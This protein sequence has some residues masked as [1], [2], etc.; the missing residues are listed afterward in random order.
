MR[1]PIYVFVGSLCLAVVGIFVMAFTVGC[2]PTPE[3]PTSPEK[4]SIKLLTY[5]ELSGGINAGVIE[6]VDT[7][8][9]F[10][11]VRSYDNSMAIAPLE[12]SQDVS[13]IG[14]E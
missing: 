5:E 12:R 8:E 14:K 7:E 13:R 3:F 6:V 2:S 4:P 10:I 9:Q 11:F 1:D